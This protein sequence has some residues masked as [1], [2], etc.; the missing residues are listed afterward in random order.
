VL[1]TLDETRLQEIAKA[2]NGGYY[3][4]AAGITELAAD[5]GRL[6]KQ[7]FRIRADGDYQERFQWFVVGALILLVCE[8]LH[9][10]LWFRKPRR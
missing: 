2:G 4:A 5:L 8:V 1:T 9:F 3:P 6:E 10:A 7:K